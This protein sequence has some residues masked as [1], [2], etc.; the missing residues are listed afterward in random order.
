[1]AKR[2]W[3]DEELDRLHKIIEDGGQW[4]VE[5]WETYSY[6]QNANAEYDY[7]AAME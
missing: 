6:I 2:T 5:D 4:T 1:M 7:Y 3:A